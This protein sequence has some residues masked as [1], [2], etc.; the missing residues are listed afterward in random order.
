MSY[1]IYQLRNKPYSMF[2]S[3]MMKKTYVFGIYLIENFS[4]KY[5]QRELKTIYVK[6]MYYF[7]FKQ[8]HISLT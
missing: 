3:Y 6:L 8:I 4:R 2:I 5:L 1:N 7:Y